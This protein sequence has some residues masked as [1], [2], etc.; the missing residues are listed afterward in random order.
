MDFAK[1]I[2]KFNPI[3]IAMDFVVEKAYVKVKKAIFSSNQKG[4]ISNDST[5]R[6]RSS[7]KLIFKK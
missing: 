6:K 2:F 4:V 1:L 5:Q 7:P 3:N